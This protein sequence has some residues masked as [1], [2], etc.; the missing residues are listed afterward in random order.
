MLGKGNRSMRY[1]FGLVV[2]FG[3]IGAAYGSA[4][5]L[6]SEDGREAQYWLGHSVVYARV[7]EIRTGPAGAGSTLAGAVTT[8]ADAAAVVRPLGALSGRFDPGTTPIVPVRLLR[9]TEGSPFPSTGDNILLVLV[10]RRYWGRRDPGED[11]YAASGNCIEYLP[12]RSSQFSVVKGFSDP[13]F[14]DTLKAVQSLRKEEAPD[15]AYD[16]CLAYGEV[17]AVRRDR[18]SGAGVVVIRPKER[19][20]GAFDATKDIEIL[21]DMDAV[22]KHK[23]FMTGSNIVV[24]FWSR[25]RPGGNSRA[26]SIFV[27]PNSSIPAD[28]SPICKVTGLDDPA[29]AEMLATFRRCTFWETHSLVY[30]ELVGT[31]KSEG[32]PPENVLD[33]RPKLALSGAF[34]CGKTPKVSASVAMKNPGSQFNLS[35]LGSKVL[36]VLTRSGDSYSITADSTPFMPGDHLPICP[37]KDF[38]DPVVRE[39]L[40]AVQKLRHATVGTKPKGEPAKQ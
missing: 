30:A 9:E 13:A 23:F 33:L 26:Y 37:V 14:A 12:T 6:G 36:V 5:G 24:W 40:A 31:A 2:G 34:D 21:A 1:C 15:P 20:S 17:R 7:E 10:D 22:L 25:A 16:P 3:V 19:L 29:V 35:S 39:T 38:D 32:H 11:R 27:G 4:A 18:Y 8:V 28:R